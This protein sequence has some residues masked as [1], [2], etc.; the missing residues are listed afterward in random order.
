MVQGFEHTALAS[1]DPEKLAQWYVDAFGFVIN[2]HSA[3]SKTCFV[4]APNGSMLEIILANPNPRP[5]QTLRDVGIRH[6]AVAVTDFDAAYAKLKSMGVAFLSEPENNKGN[7]LV[8]FTD[9][10]GNY[11]HLLQREKPLP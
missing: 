2:Y 1:P 10:D 7:R 11:L 8:F 5:P 6:L 9:P 4:K 3:S